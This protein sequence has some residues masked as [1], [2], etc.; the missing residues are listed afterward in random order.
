MPINEIYIN[1][2]FTNLLR[3][4]APSMSNEDISNCY[5]SIKAAIDTYLQLI[6]HE[7]A[8]NKPRKSRKSLS[9][10]SKS[11]HSV[12]MQ[13]QQLDTGSLVALVRHGY[14][15]QTTIA[16]ISNLDDSASRAA[17]DSIEQPDKAANHHLTYLVGKIH[18]LLGTALKPYGRKS[19]KAL[20]ND[21][22]AL[23]SPFRFDEK[24]QGT[25]KPPRGIIPIDIDRCFD[26][27][28]KLKDVYL[29]SHTQDQ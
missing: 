24:Y 7:H 19:T 25:L 17:Q 2:D 16:I 12:H 13:L 20:V 4:K 28:L 27:A 15:P 6:P 14:K 23:V 9:K 5:L 29:P 11:V 18:Y 21:V 10:L 8:I 1:K 3:N 26:N 22:F